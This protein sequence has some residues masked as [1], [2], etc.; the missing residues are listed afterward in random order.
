VAAFGLTKGLFTTDAVVI[1]FA[2]RLAI[3][4]LVSLA[5]FSLPLIGFGNKRL[6]ICFLVSFARLAL[7]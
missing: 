4:R 5:R 3:C 1:P 2:R 7:S 6:A